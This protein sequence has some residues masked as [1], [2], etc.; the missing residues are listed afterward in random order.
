VTSA[1]ATPPDAPCTSIVWPGRMP[2]RVKSI[3][4]AVSHAVPMHAASA[5][6]SDAGL[7]STLRAGTTTFS[8]NVPW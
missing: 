5:N 8:A 3:R 6:D 7:G 2:D 1:V 4:Y